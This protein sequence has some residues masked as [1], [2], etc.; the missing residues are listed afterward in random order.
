MDLDSGTVVFA[1]PGKGKD[2]LKPFWKRLRN[3]RT[4]IRAVAADMASAYYAAV[5]KNLPNATLVFD[6]FHIVKLM[7][8]KL[9]ALRRERQREAEGEPH[10][11]VLK[12]T[13][14]LL[15]ICTVFG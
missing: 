5:R 8:E 3:S 2:A 6:R 10:K 12:G 9:T 4:R 15:L 1:A 13:R 7:N 11:T 14:W